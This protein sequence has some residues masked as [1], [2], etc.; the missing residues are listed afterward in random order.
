MFEV[1]I[2]KGFI[3]CPC[4]LKALNYDDRISNTGT[5]SITCHREISKMS[6]CYAVGEIY[7][8]NLENIIN[9][10]GSENC[11]VDIKGNKF[12]H[13]NKILHREDGPAIE[14]SIGDKY[15]YIHGEL[16]RD[17]EPA[18]EC[19]NGHKLWYCKNKL[20]REDGPAITTKLN[21]NKWYLNGKNY[22]EEQYDTIIKFKAFL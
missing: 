3:H 10:S 9:V 21:H 5:C 13:L 14:F 8:P 22:S 17:N 20:H 18:I 19:S 15:W 1:Y 6:A 7:V 2:P 11:I 12:Y 16:H 4:C